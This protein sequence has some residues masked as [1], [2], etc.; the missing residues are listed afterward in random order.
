M[1]QGG[2][3]P[4]GAVTFEGSPGARV[5]NIELLKG[6]DA[7]TFMHEMG[8]VYLEVLNDLAA[9]D[10]APAQIVNDMATLNAWLTPWPAKPIRA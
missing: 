1:N 10:G 6:M 2:E 4:R 9:R 7:S 3:N 8:H 5:F